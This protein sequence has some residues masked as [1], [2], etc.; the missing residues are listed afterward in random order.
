MTEPQLTRA[1]PTYWRALQYCQQQ[2]CYRWLKGPGIRTSHHGQSPVWDA[3]GKDD[4]K[5]RWL[6]AAEA[7]S[8]GTVRSRLLSTHPTAGQ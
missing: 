3:L 7:D 5:A 2:L 6:S 4:P 1:Q 8:A